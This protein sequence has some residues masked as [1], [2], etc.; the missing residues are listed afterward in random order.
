MHEQS[1][2]S[3]SPVRSAVRPVGKVQADGA[4]AAMPSTHATFAHVGRSD[5]VAGEMPGAG[6]TGVLVVIELGS[7]QSAVVP[8][9]DRSESR[10]RG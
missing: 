4:A 7:S 2:F 3:R 10:R 5:W 1:A 9:T 8:G 6:R